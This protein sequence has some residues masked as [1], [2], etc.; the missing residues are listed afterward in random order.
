MDKADRSDTRKYPDIILAGAPKCGTT[1][2]FDYLEGHP[3]ICASSVKET[4]FLMDKG[5]PLTGDYNIHEHG[6]KGYQHYFSHCRDE[7]GKL[8]LEAT[9]DYLYQMTAVKEIPNWPEKPKVFFVLRRPE[10][11]VYSLFKF[12]QNN[13]SR[14]GTDMDFV[15]FLSHIEQGEFKKTNKIILANAIEHSRYINHLRYWREAIGAENIGLFLFED[16]VREPSVFMKQVSEYLGIDPGYFDDFDF[17]VSN[18]TYSIKSQRLFFV[19]NIISKILPK[20]RYRSLL[21][22]FYQ[23][24]NIGKA[25]KKSTDDIKEIARLHNIFVEYN[26]MLR[27][28]FHLDLSSWD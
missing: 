4:Y 14:I 8:R 21:S 15:Q 18:Q 5:Y 12:A 6:L 23:Q 9:P 10:D 17:T 20:G 19:K 1:S 3:E 13:I 26:T 16:L 7:P 28:E 11:R 27:D 24:L 2:V 25:K 22:K